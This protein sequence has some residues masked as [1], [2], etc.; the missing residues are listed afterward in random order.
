ML[1]KSCL[2]LLVFLLL[3]ST[4]RSAQSDSN[5]VL[6]DI[7]QVRSYRGDFLREI[8]FPLG[9]IG[10]GNITL[11]GR[12]ELRDW[13][14]FNR[15][16]KGKKP[17]V[18]FFAIWARRQGSPAIARILER[19]FFPPYTG[20][21]GLP[22]QSL[23][24]L[25]RLEE[26]SFDGQFPLAW[27]QF[28][29]QALPVKLKLEA[30]NPTIPL[31]V[32]NSSL[33]VAILN[34]IATNPHDVPVEI[35]IAFSLRNP[36]GTDGKDFGESLVRNGINEFVDNGTVR[37]LKFS[38][39][40]LTPD[41]ARFGSI[42]IVTTES[43]INVQTSWYRGG[44]WD[45][46]HIFWDQFAT[47]GR[48]AERR[49]RTVSP[50]NQTDIATLIVRL[51][52]QPHA[53]RTVPFYLT[54]HFPQRENYWN[55][56]AAVKGQKLKNYYARRFHDA[57]AVAQYVVSHLPYLDTTTRRF[58]QSLFGSTL[59]GYVLDAVSSQIAVL[60]TNTVMRVDH[61]EF[62]GFEGISDDGGCCPMNCTHVW[63]YAQTAAYLY[64][65]LE[66]SARETDF[67]A[68]TFGNGYMVFRSLIPLGDHWWQFKPCADG[69]MGCIVRAYRE[70]KLSGD[71]GWLKKIWTPL[72]RALEFAWKGVGEV[73]AELQ[74]QKDN[75]PI[76][77]D[78]D[79]DGVLE[80]EQHNTYDIE[81]YG[82]NTMTGS[83][84]L[85]ALKAATEM[86][87]AVSDHA[88]ARDYEQLFRA[89]SRKYDQMLWN[90]NYYI[91][92]VQIA[93]GVKVPDWLQTPTSE[94]ED[95]ESSLRSAPAAAAGA[96]AE[97]ELPPKYQYGDGCLSD[98]LLGQYE[99]FVT[100]LG[101]LLPPDHVRQA[102]KAIFDHNFRTNL[103]T[104]PNVQRVYALND[105]AGLLLCSWPNGNR[106]RLPF[107]YSDEVWTGIE[108][109]VAASLI[110]AGW[111]DEGLTIVKAVRDRHDGNRRNPWDEFECGHHYARAMASWA[112]LLALSGFHYDGVAQTMQ[113]SPV[114]QQDHFRTF[115]S[116][117][118]GW[119]QFAQDTDQVSLQV[120]FGR[121]ELRQLVVQKKQSIRPGQILL[122]GQPIK[123]RS[124]DRQQRCS[125]RFVTPVS[126]QAGDKLEVK[127][128]H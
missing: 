43:T 90:G 75:L 29:D 81:F 110:Y 113:F 27:L 84:Y 92:Q 103:A 42:A 24:G 13:E 70:W 41:D 97:P 12:G 21:M 101:Y 47:D 26:V 89:G 94:I 63:N 87:R 64:P 3:A 69:Q 22:R 93:P 10:T 11:G 56:E 73:T 116:A 65:E 17:D 20:W 68:N 77:W 120:D 7:G 126:L 124:H 115:W 4:M 88:A 112:V 30:Y 66:R 46:A 128:V 96:V 15:P 76:P 37:G 57:V 86:A 95:A 100:G 117:G 105:E 123:F 39:N 83:I 102:L 71:T 99:A 25:P 45:N 49:A 119:G 35:A 14:I 16:G 78:A 107:V 19:Q 52:L 51:T 1:A 114:W 125:I 54:W 109:Q 6:N 127:F 72:K 121:L 2:L 32:D 28:Q 8:G 85:A 91:Q 59:P 44:W 5:Q 62:F 60:K 31:D 79:K 55:R 61:G 38:S 106:P 9:G 34:W 18:A 104:F 50:E 111:I 98:Q 33:P 118:T 23:P 67:L 122:Q 82:P 40:Y 48:I 58:H 53:T 74:W 36:I 80:A 108:Y